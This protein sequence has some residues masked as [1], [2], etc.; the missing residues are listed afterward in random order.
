MK[1]VEAAK[2]RGMAI[3]RIRQRPP[4]DVDVLNL[5]TTGLLWAV[6][7]WATA[8]GCAL[9]GLGGGLRLG[10]DDLL[11]DLSAKR[12]EAVRGNHCGSMLHRGNHLLSQCCT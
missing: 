1:N 6:I 5:D 12:L 9:S 2:P 7:E 11:V 4:A 3:A 8:K 10:L